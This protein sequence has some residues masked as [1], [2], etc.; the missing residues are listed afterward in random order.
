MYPGAI[1]AVTPDKPAVIMAGSGQVVTYR[2]LD[3]ESN[4]LAHLFRA[5]GLRPGDHIAFML[6]N[7]PLFLAIAWAAH[8]SGLYYTAISSR[9]QHDELAYIVDNCGARVFISSAGLADVATSIT[10]D[11]PRVELRLMLDGTAEGF[12]SYEEA[13]AGHPVTPVDGEVQGADML[14]SSGTTGRPKGVPLTHHNVFYEVACTDRMADL[15]AEG[16]QISYLTYA[17]IAERVL[18]LYLPLVKI[19]HV[20]FC[21]DLANLGTVL[22]QVR[23]VLF[24]GVPR[25]WEKMMAKLLAVLS[26]QPEEQQAA[27]RQAMAAGVAWVEAGQYGHTMTPE[28]QEAYEKADSSLLSIVRGMIGFDRAKWTATGAA[29]LPAEVQRFYAGLGLKVIDVY[30]MTETTGAFTGN[31]PTCYQKQKSNI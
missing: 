1:A 16:T 11:T 21:T 15:P 3:E 5:A 14:Y 22:G 26:T 4:R 25:V 2:Q 6:P 27:V 23:P 8:R 17:H 31:A 9:L 18:S 28:I 29:P 19:S 13:V 12:Q 10:A 7:H 20:Y 24:F 30:G